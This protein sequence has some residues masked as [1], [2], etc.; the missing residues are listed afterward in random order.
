MKNNVCI[1]DSVNLCVV[2]SEIS[3]NEPENGYAQS[4]ASNDIY[5]N[6]Q[7]EKEEKDFIENY[8][9]N[10]SDEEVARIRNY[11]VSKKNSTTAAITFLLHKV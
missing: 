9:E 7:S 2:P 3:G 6:L 11:L 5:H 8:A 10:L 4:N 1:L